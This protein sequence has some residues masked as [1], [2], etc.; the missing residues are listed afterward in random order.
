MADTCRAEWCIGTPVP[1]SPY[2]AIHKQL[3]P[4]H[5]MESHNEWIKRT[6]RE[7][8]ARKRAAERAAESDAAL[9]KRGQSHG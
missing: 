4:L 6:N 8:A 1:G 7:R 9:A 5:N 2:C 3:P